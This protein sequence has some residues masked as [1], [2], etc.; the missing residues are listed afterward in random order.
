MM[1]KVILYLLPVFL[2]V[3]ACQKKVDPADL[4]NLNGYWEISKAVMPD[5]EIK[6]Y[7]VN[8]AIDFFQ[9]D[10]QKGFRQ[11]VVPQFDGEYLTNQVQEQIEVVDFD[12]KMMLKYHTDFADWQEELISISSEELVV[13]NEH[14]ITYYYKRAIPFS[15]K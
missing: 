4:K 15:K 7:T 2:L 13:K 14:D 10:S 8:M 3:V 9:V 6:E 12:G 5:G 11:K 1:K